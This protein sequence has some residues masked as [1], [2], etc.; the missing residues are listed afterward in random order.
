MRKPSIMNRQLAAS[1]VT[2]D[3]LSAQRQS[4]IESVPYS[5]IATDLEGVITMVNPAAERM[6]GYTRDQLLGQAV[7]TKIHDISE[8]ENRALELSYE[9][10]TPIAADFSVFSV[11][12]RH[13]VKEEREWTYLRIDGTSLTVNLMVSALHNAA[14]EITGYLGVANDVSERKRAEAYI[15]HMAHHDALTGLPNRALLLDRI[16][17]AIKRA[18]RD[19]TQVALLMMDLDHFKRIN[20]TLGHHMGDRLLLIVAARL[21][22]CLRETDTVARLGGDEF[23]VVLG[24][25]TSREDLNEILMDMVQKIAAPIRIETHEM[26]V[27][28]SIGG[29]LFPDDGQD[30][31]T[32]LKSADTAMYQAKG[33]GRNTWQWFTQE[34]L[35]ATEEKLAITNALRHALE[36]KELT[37]HYQP[38]ISLITGQVIGMEAL[39]R[40]QH[41]ERGQISPESFISLAEE[42]GLIL[43][44]G[45]WV[46]KTACAEAVRT[47]QILGRPLVIAVNVS[48]RQLQQR[49]WIESVQ[50]ALE[51]S[52]LNPA[53]LELEITESMLI[54]DPKESAATLKSL[55]K[56]GVSIAIDDFGT[57]YSSL[58]YIMR[59]PIDK[60]KID[61]SFV[62]ALN[63]KNTDAAIINAII[64]MAHSLELKVV[65]EGVETPEQLVYLRKRGCDQAQGFYFGQAIPIEEFQKHVHALD[66]H[67]PWRELFQEH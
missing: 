55:R 58:S 46:L 16:E 11:K 40:W 12:A 29:A 25:V 50:S 52:G 10:G 66:L 17:M 34:M 4:I 62:S 5:M 33:I 56:L 60:L 15:R 61:R 51:E 63:N 49:H 3:T 44:I 31:N 7:V 35:H 30:A 19:N 22:F 28:P 64:A 2:E 65:A 38:Q 32:L 48:P 6:L 59:F 36:R 9:M 27:T 14:G 1:A 18:R 47:Q 39:I 13:G 20:D 21:Q 26:M 57:G 37:L 43:P 42:T 53:N 23:V 41:P 67:N 54:K 45:D 24:D 8:V